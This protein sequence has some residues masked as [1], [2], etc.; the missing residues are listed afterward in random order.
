MEQIAPPPF[1]HHGAESIQGGKLLAK[2]ERP[3]P[4]SLSNEIVHS[5]VWTGEVPDPLVR[6]GDGVTGICAEALRAEG[7]RSLTFGLGLRGEFDRLK[8]QALAIDGPAV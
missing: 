3:K 7:E 4:R 6:L 2:N 5:S 1:R 8:P